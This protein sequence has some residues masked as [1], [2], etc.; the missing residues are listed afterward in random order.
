V[1]GDTTRDYATGNVR[2]EYMLSRTFFV[3]GSYTYVYQKYR[4]QTNSAEANVVG[5]SFGYRGLER[6]R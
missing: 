2:M 5:V 3:A 1:S 6:Q 4:V